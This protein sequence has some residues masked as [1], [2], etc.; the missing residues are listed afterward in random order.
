M[1]RDQDA[2]SARRI[3]R[4]DVRPSSWKA[5]QTPQSGCFHAS[6]R[7]VA[8]SAAVG[9]WWLGRGAAGGFDLINRVNRDP[10]PPNR[11][12]ERPT[13]NRMDNSDTAI[14]ER[15]TAVWAACVLTPLTLG[16]RITGRDLHALAPC[17]VLV[18]HVFLVRATLDVSTS[19]AVISA[20]AKLLVQSCEATTSCLCVGRLR[21]RP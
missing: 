5:M 10:A 18:T 19:S 7:I 21:R 14:G 4:L 16:F 15:L 9:G 20:P 13:E 8:A 1:R 2:A 11:A 12:S 17:G 3:P 6:L